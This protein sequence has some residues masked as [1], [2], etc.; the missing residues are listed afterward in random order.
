[1][2][3][4]EKQFPAF[5]LSELKNIS[6]GSLEGEKDDKLPDS[7]FITS[8]ILDL[9]ENKYN[10]VLSPKGGGKSALFRSLNMKLIPSKSVIDYDKYSI[11]GVNTAFGFD[12]DYLSTELFKEDQNRRNYTLAWGVFLLAELIKDIQK[13]H[14]QKDSYAELF[15]KIKKIKDFKE[16]FNLYDLSDYLGDLSFGLSF[17]V[18]GVPI[19]VK[20]KINFK[21][22][23]EKLIL[24]EIFKHINDFYEEN[25]ITGLI[26]IDRLDNFVRKESYPIQK[27]YIQGL[28][29]CIEELSNFKF[30]NCLLFIRTD[31]FYHFDIDFEYDKLK[32]RTQNLLWK[33]GE[34]LSF[35]VYR[36]F[37]NSYIKDRYYEYFNHL[38]SQGKEGQQIIYKKNNLWQRFKFWIKGKKEI[39]DLKKTIDYT[40]AEKFLRLFFPENLQYFDNKNF[41]YWIFTYLQDANGFINPRLIIYFF[42]E[43]IKAQLAFNTKLN[44]N[45]L[46][47]EVE[48]KKANDVFYF[49]LFSQ[50][51]FPEV[52]K[53]IQNDEILNIYKILKEKNY[54]TLFKEINN[55]TLVKRKFN[56][57]DINLKRFDIPKEEY[58]TLLKYLIL[59]GYCKEVEKQKYEV[60]NLYHCELIL[61]A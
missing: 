15:N 41:C 55:K 24:N 5:N 2:K 43:L 11:I 50:E 52:Y 59:L 45:S 27:N 13:N 44:I 61:Q 33:D 9:F 21:S 17:N 18:G 16:K 23:S 35:I 47:T 46:Q 12:D 3:Q 25:N 6:F 49:N 48:I 42:N 39:L 7:F 60:P 10:Y 34:I 30:I 38:L 40:I 56:Y 32:E 8:S 28:I 53:K 26:L 31:L 58:D 29:D 14:S 22:K 20:P 19:D 4:F 37:S 57:G 54:H 36:L 51:L 1:M